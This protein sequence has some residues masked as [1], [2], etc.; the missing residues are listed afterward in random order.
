MIIATVGYG[1]CSGLRVSGHKACPICGPNHLESRRSKHL[2][3]IVYQGYRKYLP[4]GHALL[5]VDQNHAFNAMT[6]L[7]EKPPTMDP[8]FWEAQWR[9]V[10]LPR[11]D[12]RHIQ[13][14]TS[15]MNQLSSFY[16]LP[17]FKVNFLSPVLLATLRIA[18]LNIFYYIFILIASYIF[19]FSRW[20]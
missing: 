12:P 20:F 4:P 3:K 8:K 14:K 13:L 2:K 5:G 7:Q 10:H 11:E 1:L 17:Y 19:Y 9:R 16:R 18:M 15:G 6:E